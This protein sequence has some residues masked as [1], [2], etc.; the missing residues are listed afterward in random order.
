[1]K[2]Y[3]KGQSYSS[4]GE[5]WLGLNKNIMKTNFIITTTVIIAVVFL[6]ICVTENSSGGTPILSVDAK[7]GDHGINGKF[8]Y[9][10]NASDLLSL[11]FQVI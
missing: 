11:Y 9:S 7:D 10:I 1:M 3:L 2:K 8:L 6:F 5:R 4:R